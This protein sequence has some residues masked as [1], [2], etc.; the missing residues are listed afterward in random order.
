MATGQFE[1]VESGESDLSVSLVGRVQIHSNAGSEFQRSAVK[2]IRVP[3]FAA[4]KPVVEFGAQPERGQ[5]ERQRAGH[6]NHV[7]LPPL[8]AG[9]LSF[10]MDLNFCFVT[11]TKKSLQVVDP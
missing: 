5:A 11:A 7:K 1:F 10:T 2:Q 3:V 9:G 4:V 8:V 6:T